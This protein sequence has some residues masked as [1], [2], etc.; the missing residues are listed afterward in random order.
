MSWAGHVT[1]IIEKQRHIKF[2]S[3]ILSCDIRGEEM[4][5]LRRIF[6]K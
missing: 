1:G 2:L 6:Y 3:R 4:I 5:I